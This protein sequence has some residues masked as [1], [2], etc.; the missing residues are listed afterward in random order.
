MDTWEYHYIRLFFSLLTHVQTEEISNFYARMN[1]TEIDFAFY[2]QMRALL[3]VP[4]SS[5][6]DLA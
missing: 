2:M 5:K 1:A 6:Y 4:V 3:Q